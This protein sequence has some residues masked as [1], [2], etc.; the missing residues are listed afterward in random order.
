MGHMMAGA[1]MCGVELKQTQRGM[2][3]CH[4][5]VLTTLAPFGMCI[6]TVQATVSASW[7]TRARARSFTLIPGKDTENLVT[8]EKNV[9]IYQ[10]LTLVSHG[11]WCAAHP[12]LAYMHPACR[13]Y[14]NLPL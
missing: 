2:L 14:V 7:S 12:S 8:C 4:Q 11:P 5:L 9:M 3:Q 1:Y 13:A 6:W 10:D